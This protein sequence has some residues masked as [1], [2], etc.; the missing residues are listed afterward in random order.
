M[1]AGTFYVAYEADQLG[2]S[3]GVTPQHNPFPW[4]VFV[5]GVVASIVTFSLGLGLAMLCA[6]YDQQEV[7][8]DRFEERKRSKV[9]P[10][11][12]PPFPP[13]SSRSAKVVDTTS[14]GHSTAPSALT[15]A[16]SKINYSREAVDSGNSN[17]ERSGLWEKLTRERHLSR[18]ELERGS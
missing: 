18:K 5:T 11:E 8:T 13:P 3:L 7:R 14:F 2:W 1:C 6:I 4:I 10:S 17:K 15:T 16:T 12:E 9:S